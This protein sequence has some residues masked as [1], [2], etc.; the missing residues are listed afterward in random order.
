MG[1]CNIDPELKSDIISG[2]LFK[3]IRDDIKKESF[4][5]YRPLPSQPHPGFGIRGSISKG[6]V[7]NK[8]VL[9][10][11]K[12]FLKIVFYSV[13]PFPKGLGASFKLE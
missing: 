3:N 2:Q 4:Q 8:I 5:F 10:A 1:S 6:T 12:L 9:E 13:Q 7:K 11:V